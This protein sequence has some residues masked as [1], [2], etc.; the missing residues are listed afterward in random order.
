MSRNT[1]NN[2]KEKVSNSSTNLIQS[3]FITDK[4]NIVKKKVVYFFFS[5]FHY[6]NSKILTD[7]FIYILSVLS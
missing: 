3:N 4:I 7:L 2:N 5:F 1:T 6:I